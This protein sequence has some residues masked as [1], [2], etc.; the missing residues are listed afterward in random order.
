MIPLAPMLILSL[1]SILLAPFALVWVLNTALGLSLQV[2]GFW[3]W[4]AWLFLIVWIRAGVT[5]N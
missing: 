5:K 2:N 3:G 1:V 4:L